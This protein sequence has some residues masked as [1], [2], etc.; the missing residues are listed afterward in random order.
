MS[1]VWTE[2]SVPMTDHECAVEAMEEIGAT[3]LASNN[4]Q[5]R[6]RISGQEW[7]MR[8]QHGRYSIRYNRA[9]QSTSLN[10]M[11]NLGAVYEQAVQRKLRRLQIEEETAQLE[12]ER[13]KIRQER[14]AFENQRKELIEQRKQE[15]LEKAKALGYRVKQTEQNG[16]IRMVLVRTG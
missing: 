7:V 6:I 9:T 16:Q 11:N 1:G 13:E 14:E 4:N 3:I 15:I 10:W 2:R 8:R 5:I 12:S